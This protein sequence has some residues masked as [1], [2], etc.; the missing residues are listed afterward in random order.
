MPE[1]DDVDGRD[2]GAV[3]LLAT[4]DG[5]AAGTARILIADGTGKIGRVC[6]LAPAR[7]AGL[8]VLLVRAAVAVLRATPGIGQARLGAQ[9]HALGFYAALGFAA[10]GPVY[11]DAGIAHRDMVL[12]L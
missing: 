8:G 7:G 5:R 11:D 9:V 12:W 1:A 4:V 3:H 6:V 10:E 2:A